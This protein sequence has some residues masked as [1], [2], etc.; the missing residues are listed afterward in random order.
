MSSLSISQR[1]RRSLPSLVFG[2]AGATLFIFTAC[3]VEAR[4]QGMDVHHALISA[5]RSII[6]PLPTMLIGWTLGALV[7]IFVL[8]RS[9][10]AEGTPVEAGRVICRRMRTGSLIAFTILILAFAWA[11]LSDLANGQWQGRDW[12]MLAVCLSL[13]LLSVALWQA[14]ASSERLYAISTGDTSRVNDERMQRVQEKAALVTMY[15]FQA[16]LV[17]AVLPYQAIVLGHWPAVTFV[18][19]GVILVTSIAATT[20]WNR[21]L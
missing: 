6:F 16:F 18:E 10:G 4:Q 11:V 21:R 7:A 8:S 14:G 12:V 3:A 5:L 20:Y 19:I 1:I 13:I 2:L 17:F 15:I 9:T